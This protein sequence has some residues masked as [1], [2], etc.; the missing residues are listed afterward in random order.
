MSNL[1]PDVYLNTYPFP[2]TEINCVYAISGTYGLLPRLLYYFTLIFAIFG[3]RNEWLI[4]GALVSALTYAGTTAFH[5]MA[6]SSSKSNVFDLDI[7]ASWAV[8]STGALAYI[9]MMHWSSTMRNSEARWVMIVWGWLVGC[10]LIFGRSSLYTTPLHGTEP[11]CYSRSGVLLEYPLQALQNP[12]FNCSYKCFDVVKPMRHRSEIMA[13]PHRI[14]HKNGYDTLTLILVGPIQF[15]A[16]AAL[17]LDSVA[18]TPSQQCI[19]IVMSYLI[20]PG[21]REQFTKAVYQASRETWYG[22][23]FALLGYVRRTKW[24]YK[25]W[26][27]CWLLI[28]WLGLALLVDIL[29]LPLMLCNIVLNEMSLWRG[30][31]P[32]N[33]SNLA[34]GQWGPIVNSVLVLLAAIMIKCIEVWKRRKQIKKLDELD[35]EGGV[36]EEIDVEPGIVRKDTQEVGLV[37]PPLAHVETLRD[38]DDWIRRPKSSTRK[39]HILW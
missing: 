23:Y 34:I 14:L 22:G 36:V 38:A 39:D 26:L 35:K 29:C 12:E 5:A 4:I 3:R 8:L 33:E 18:H 32:V 9:G 1:N 7:I 20:H 21:H 30:A 25:K 37:K 24:S 10:A 27:L 2:V 19:R 13:V 6:L 31:L 17:S 28:P 11:A 16:Y 15:A